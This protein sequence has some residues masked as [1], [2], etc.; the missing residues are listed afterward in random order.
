MKWGYQP[1]RKRTSG[2]VEFHKSLH[3]E[4]KKTNKLSLLLTKDEISSCKSYFKGL[5]KFLNYYV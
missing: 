1:L 3:T 5:I 4:N 2:R